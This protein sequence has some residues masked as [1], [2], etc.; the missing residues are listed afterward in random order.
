M[1]AEVAKYSAEFLQVLFELPRPILSE[2]LSWCQQCVQTDGKTVKT[3]RLASL[4]Y[5][6]KASSCRSICLQ[7]T[8]SSTTGPDFTKDGFY[9]KFS[10]MLGYFY[11]DIVGLE[12]ASGLRSDQ[13]CRRRVGKGDEFNKTAPAPPAPT[14]PEPLRQQPGRMVPAPLTSFPRLRQVRVPKLAPAILRP[15]R[16][17]CR[18]RRLP[19]QAATADE[20]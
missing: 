4:H 9:N 19:S 15:A 16:A 2:K 13:P 3:V 7:R 10:K 20:K 12:G 11:G 8:L 6:F 5:A 17:L 14:A 1:I 18:A